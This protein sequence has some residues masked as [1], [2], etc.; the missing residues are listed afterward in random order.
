MFPYFL[1]LSTC[2]V[3]LLPYIFTL[4]S[5]NIFA[6][7]CTPSG[8]LQSKSRVRSGDGSPLSPWYPDIGHSP[9]ST[10]APLSA[11]RSGQGPDQQMHSPHTRADYLHSTFYLHSTSTF[12]LLR[13]WASAGDTRHAAAG[14]GA[15]LHHQHKLLTF[16][17]APFDV[18]WLLTKNIYKARISIFFTTTKYPSVLL[19]V[20][21]DRTYYGLV[22]PSYI[23]NLL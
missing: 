9:L 10:L 3:L 2:C 16:I 22:T 20:T 8:Q 14:Y 4:P 15:G 18:V 5:P 17:R 6:G 7:G 1:L 12:K 11:P 23:A 13:G 21:R 19:L